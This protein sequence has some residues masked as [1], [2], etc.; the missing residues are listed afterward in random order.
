MAGSKR[1]KK[2]SRLGR[3]VEKEGFN[4]TELAEIIECGLSTAYA[5]IKGTFTPGRE[6]G[7]RIEEKTWGEVP[8]N[9]TS[10]PELKE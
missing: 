5:L 7:W 8:F 4:A 10:W 9:R 1:E 3:W 2:L 6:L